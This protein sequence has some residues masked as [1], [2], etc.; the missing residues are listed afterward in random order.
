MSQFP[1][2]LSEALFLSYL[3]KVN[4]AFENFKIP[5]GDSPI[6]PLSDHIQ[7]GATVLLR[8]HFYSCICLISVKCA[9]KRTDEKGAGATSD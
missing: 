7:T 8:P 4:G 9:A 5:L 1:S 2:L 3:K 6:F